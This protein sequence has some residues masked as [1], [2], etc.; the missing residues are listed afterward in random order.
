MLFKFSCLLALLSVVHAT[1]KVKIQKTTF[2][3]RDVTGLKQDF[4]GGENCS[5]PTGGII[6]TPSPVPGIPFAEPPLGNLRLKPPVLKPHLDVETFDASNF[7]KGC[8]QPV[9]F[10]S[11]NSALQLNRYLLSA[12]ATSQMHSQKTA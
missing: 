4:F 11:F 1:P 3:G 2:I 5:F 8:L 10:S 12:R 6:L 7:G 9:S